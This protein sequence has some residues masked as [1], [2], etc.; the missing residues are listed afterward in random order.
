MAAITLTA[1]RREAVA[2]RHDAPALRAWLLENLAEV[3]PLLGLDLATAPEQLTSLDDA[4]DPCGPLSQLPHRVERWTKES[5]KRARDAKAIAKDA[6][7]ST[8]AAQIATY[9]ATYDASAS[10]AT[11]AHSV[12]IPLDLVRAFFDACTDDR[13][14][15]IVGDTYEEK[16]LGTLGQR[17]AVRSRLGTLVI[18]T[19]RVRALLRARKDVREVRLEAQIDRARDAYAIHR[20]CPVGKSK[21]RPARPAGV[22]TCEP[23]PNSIAWTLTITCGE[24]CR[25]RF[26]AS[27]PSALDSLSTFVD[28]VAARA[29]MP[30][31]DAPASAPR[32][33]AAAAPACTC[34]ARRSDACACRAESEAA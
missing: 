12:P 6:A 16:T 13:V 1:I 28:V 10:D 17:I 32:I 25:M 24:R 11:V 19:A 2:L 9:A 33:A 26:A 34:G 23:I 7:A 18:D 31:V 3:A 4:G 27:D 15:F 14:G 5:A 8:L 29:A 20:P 30:V 21:N 22:E